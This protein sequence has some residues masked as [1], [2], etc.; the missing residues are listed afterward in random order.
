MKKR[1]G[2]S[3]VAVVGLVSG[4]A[5]AVEPLKLGVS[6][7]MKQ[8]FGVVNQTT[9]G[10]PYTSAQATA[11]GGRDYA[12][13]GLASDTEVY[14][15]ASTTLDN[16]L[17][18]EARVE[19]DIVDKG[20]GAANSTPQNVAVDEEWASIGSAKYGK[21]YA[22]VKESINVSMHNEAPDVGI[23]YGD[24]KEWIHEPS[25]M[26]MFGGGAVG[27][28]NDWDFTSFEALIDDS[29]SISYI[30]PQF[31]GLQLGVSFAPNGQGNTGGAGTI[32]PANRAY[33]QSDA[34]DATLAYTREFNGVTFGADAGIG[35]AQGSTSGQSGLTST[36]NVWNA[37]MKIGYAGFTLGGAF[38]GYN[39][40]LSTRSTSGALSLD[41]NSWNAGLSYENGPW[42]VST[43]FYHEEHRGSIGTGDNKIITSQK[44]EKFN[45][46]LLS[47]KYTLGPGIDAK[48][49][50]FYGE[51]LG[52]NYA[53]ANTNYNTKGTG[54][55]TGIDLTF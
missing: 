30:T 55:V 17:E 31:Y 33:H 2:M 34:W 40:D 5:H 50:G 52:R 24:V 1:L 44:A 42:A 4:A 9:S 10:A 26:V 29:A 53:A 28:G 20:N 22:G 54:L 6:G 15:K 36:A 8:W 45:T 43:M 14:F 16:G 37:G 39:D 12:N 3:A 23:G 48:A 35:G 32:G 25:G 41:G 21:V 13:T 7:N 11:T 19:I 47:G 27:G 38:L 46:Y 49:T 51:Y 18:I